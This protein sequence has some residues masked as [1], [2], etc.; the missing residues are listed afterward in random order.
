[1]SGAGSERQSLVAKEAKENC[2]YKVI[3]SQFIAEVF[4]SNLVTTQPWCGCVTARGGSCGR[5]RTGFAPQQ[6]LA[7]KIASAEN[8]RLA[9]TRLGSY[10]TF[11]LWALRFFAVSAINL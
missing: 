6:R 5:L 11:S 2:F 7:Q 4:L 10:Q 1:V 8:R 9:M 3:A